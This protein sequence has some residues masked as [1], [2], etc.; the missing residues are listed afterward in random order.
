MSEDT[1]CETCHREFGTQ[2]AAVRHMDI[3]AHWDTRFKCSTCDKK[4]FT[5]RAADQHM[6]DTGHRKPQVQCETCD[7]RFHTQRSAD[8]H[9]SA[10]KHRKPQFK[11]ETCDEGFG[12]QLSAIQHREAPSNYERH[13]YHDRSQKFQGGNFSNIVCFSR[14]PWCWRVFFEPAVL[15]TIVRTWARAFNVARTLR[16]RSNRCTQISIKAL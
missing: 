13:N 1:K 7:K 10:K 16:A 3:L 15:L 12:S 8:N 2:E 6:Y 11:V 4:F 14:T 5:Q 9:M